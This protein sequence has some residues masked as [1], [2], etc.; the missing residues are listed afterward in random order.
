MTLF[1]DNVDL[2]E[3]IVRRMDYG[4]I[5]KEDLMQSGLMGLFNATKKYNPDLGVKFNTFATYYIIGE[6]KKELRENQLIKLN[7]ELYRI[8]RELKKGNRLTPEE[9]AQKLKVSRENVIIA[10]NFLYHIASLNQNRSPA[11]GKEKELLEEIPAVSRR[12]HVFDAVDSLEATEKEIILWRYFKNY[13]QTEI[14]KIRKESQSNI[15]RIEARA[16]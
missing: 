11:D 10:Y 14:A 13:T 1:E 12:N 7:R 8:I 16:L 6:I 3:K 9:L 4:Y 2:V 5:S 15:S